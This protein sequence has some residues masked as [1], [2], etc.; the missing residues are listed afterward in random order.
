MIRLGLYLTLAIALA[1]GA[2]WFADQPGSLQ[3]TWRGWEVRMT[4]A[5]FCLLALLYTLL[6]LSLYKLYRWFRTDNPLTSPKRQASRHHKGQIELDLGWSALCIDDRAA[7]LNHGKKARSLLPATN[8]PLHLL[9]AASDD[10]DSQKYLDLLS[11]NENTR[12]VAL[13]QRL[14]QAL[15]NHK[16]QNAHNILLQMQTLKPTS[17]WI[18]HRLFDILTRLGSWAEA[19]QELTK[20]A[21]AKTLEVPEQKRLSAVINYAQALEADLAGQKKTAHD[22]TR[23]ALKNDPAFIPAALLMGR[24]HLAEGAPAKAAKA[25]QTIW[26]I[27]PHP[28][29][30]QFFLKLAPMESPSEKFRRIQKFTALNADHRHSRHFLAKVALD[31]DHWAEAKQALDNLVTNGQARAE[32]YHLLARLE[33][34]QKQDEAAAEAHLVQAAEMPADPPWQ[35]TACNTPRQNYTATCPTCHSFGQVTGAVAV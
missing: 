21:K 20:M 10:A 32:T 5:V 2:V 7:A 6:C 1:L 12:M 4:V 15:A 17:P 11:D 23:Q 22:F 31:T 29:L 16:T 33:R 35:C 13:K 27:A 30:A 14:D 25:M 3:L 9:L 24:H 26:K 18:S 28:D 8:G 34:L 19:A